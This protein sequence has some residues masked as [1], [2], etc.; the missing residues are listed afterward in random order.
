MK[1]ITRLAHLLAIPLLLAALF[2]D[3]LSPCPPDLLD[4]GMP[5]APPVRVRFVDASG[6]LH[7]RPFV[8][9]TEL[10]DE[11]EVRYQTR[12]D[13]VHR[14]SL[15][16]P[17]YRFHLFGLIPAT[18]HLIGT[19]TGMTVHLLGTDE[20][21]RDVLARAL[22]GTR[23]SLLVLALGLAIYFACGMII[24]ACAGMAGGWIDMVLMRFSEFVL[25]LPALYLVL[26]VRAVLPPGM[27][28][29]Q[30]A[31]LS[32][33]V[34]ASVTWP[35]MARGVRGMIL[36]LRNTGYVEAARALGASRW[37]VFR[38]HMF[39][40]LAPFSLAQT[41][42]AAPVFILGEVILSFLN[43]GF[44]GSGASWGAM[45]RN[46]TQDPRML[47]DFWWNLAPLAFV[48]ITLFC[49]HGIGRLLHRNEPTPLT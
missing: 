49:L 11:L 23:S 35:P 36:Q 43:V 6:N 48:F 46:L 42:V 26:A 4:I 24:G 30:T 28:Y 47:T 1:A 17:G 39:P 7:I 2:S 3:F 22:A 13:Q 25:A 19:D 34:I 41:A 31:L 37:D 20:L 38:R 40:A 27:A 33:T 45:L 12:R 15:F 14:L 5:Y 16:V 18:R 44:Q 21:G 8:Y 10:V 32:A 29:W 9:A